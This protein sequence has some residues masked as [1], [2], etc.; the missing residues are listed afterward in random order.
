MLTTP[1]IYFDEA[2]CFLRSPARGHAEKM[3]VIA[4][5]H[6]AIIRHYAD[7]RFT[8]VGDGLEV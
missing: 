8:G 3:P 2:P 7:E 4:D 1:F 6:A 5:F